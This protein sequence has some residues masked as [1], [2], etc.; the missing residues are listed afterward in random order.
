MCRYQNLRKM[1]TMDTVLFL[2]NTVDPFVCNKVAYFIYESFRIRDAM[3][4]S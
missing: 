3:T 1:N 4:K 2:F